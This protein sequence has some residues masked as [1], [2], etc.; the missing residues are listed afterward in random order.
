M[1]ANPWWV[2]GLKAGYMMGPEEMRDR[3]GHCPMMVTV[4]M[5]VRKP[6]EEEDEE[7]ESDEGG[8]SY[9]PPVRWPEEGD[10]G[11]C[12]QWVQ[13]VHVEMRRGSHAHGA[14]RKAATVFGFG[15]QVGE[16]QTEPKLQQLVAKPGKRQ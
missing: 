8:V 12:Q 15:R 1:Y 16:L 6:G 5:K 2:R 7:Q 3:K 10:D 13:Q 4:D 14:V 11:R 9:P